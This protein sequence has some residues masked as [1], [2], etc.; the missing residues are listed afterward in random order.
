MI[1]YF[2]LCFDTATHPAAVPQRQPGI[3][4]HSHKHYPGYC[5]WTAG[6]P[7]ADPPVPALEAVLLNTGKYTFSG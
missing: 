2:Q 6:W 5:P 4:L 7:L 3:P 1:P